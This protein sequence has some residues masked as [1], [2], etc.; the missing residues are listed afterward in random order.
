MALS[1]RI[2]VFGFRQIIAYDPVTKIPY[3]QADIVGECSFGR[4]LELISQ[5]GG[6]YADPTA[7]DIGAAT[8][9]A[10]LTIREKPDWLFEVFNG[11]AATINSAETGGSVT[12][13]ENFNGTSVVD[14]TTGIASV[15]IKAGDE[16]KV[17]EGHWVVEAVTATTINVYPLNSVDF[18]L[19]QVEY[20]NDTLAIN[21]TPFTV[22]GTGG[23]LEIVDD[24]SNT[25]ALEF[26]GGSGA[27]AM[28]PGDTAIFSS[29]RVNTGSRSALIGGTGE[30][31]K[32]FGL[33]L[34]SAKST[35]GVTETLQIYRCVAS[36]MPLTMTEKAY[37]EISLPFMPVADPCNNGAI[38]NVELTKPVVSCT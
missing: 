7:V 26:T 12:A 24:N 28:T 34:H 18:Y 17:I 37:Q 33:L 19:N 31:F 36:G 22:P 3:G 35:K 23:T 1:E 20:A 21:S 16:D 38:A 2:Q 29:R 4:T 27:I 15:G 10:S 6:S 9:E 8:A 25:L 13:I 5:T 11:N 14:A 32:E 30:N